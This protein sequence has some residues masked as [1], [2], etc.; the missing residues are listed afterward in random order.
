MKIQSILDKKSPDGK[1]LLHHLSNRGTDWTTIPPR[2]PHC[3]GIWAAA[4]ESMSRNVK[5]VDGVQ[6][7]K[8]EELLTVLQQIEAILNFRPPFPRFD[9][10]NDSRALPPARF[11]IGDSLLSIAKEETTSI[12]PNQRLKLIGGIHQEFWKSWSRDYLAEL[13]MKKRWYV[14]GPELSMSGLGSNCSGQWNSSFLET[15]TNHKFVQG[16]R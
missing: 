10:P 1:K 5:R 15:C 9:D 2:A 8:Y 16:K 4:V 14:N 6:V 12:K 13:Q 7:L 3:G 11:P